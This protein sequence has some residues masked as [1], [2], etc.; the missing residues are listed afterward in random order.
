L[1]KTIGHYVYEIDENNAVRMWDIECPNEKD[2]PFF[3]QPDHPDATP[4]EST[5]AAENWT[6][7]FINQLLTPP[8]EPIE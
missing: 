6:V 3:Y 5:E 4:W 7:N 1:K 8:Q 2:E